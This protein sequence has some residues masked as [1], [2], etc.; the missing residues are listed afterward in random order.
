MEDLLDLVGGYFCF[1]FGLWEERCCGGAFRIRRSASSNGN[2]AGFPA[3]SGRFNLV[4]WVFAMYLFYIDGSQDGHYYT[5]SALGVKD[6]VWKDFYVAVCKF[7]EYL[8]DEHGIYIRKELHATKFL[9]GRGRPSKEFLSKEDRAGIFFECLKFI[10]AD[11]R[12]FDAFLFNSA[13]DNQDW[14]FERLLNRINRT[15]RPDV[16]DD[17]AILI[18][19]EGSEWEFTKLVRRMGVYNPIPSQYGAWLDTGEAVKN[20]T[21]DRIIEDPL[22]KKSHRSTIIQLVDFCAYALLR[23]DKQVASKNAL[24]VHQG[25]ALLEPICFKGANK[26]D[27]FGVIR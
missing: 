7:R 24:D 17:R 9:S 12:K 5:F 16:K 15:M 6:S 26:K 8:R 21:L 11:L 27:K 23:Q 3:R 18:C 22:F 4:E 19:D 25:F 10:A 20:I 2:G 13:L 1:F 14:A